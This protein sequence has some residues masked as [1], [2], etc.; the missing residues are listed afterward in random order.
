MFSCYYVISGGAIMKNVP[1]RYCETRVLGCHDR[2]EKYLEYKREREQ[3]IKARSEELDASGHVVDVLRK[4]KKR[5]R[6]K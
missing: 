4:Q 6:R 5:R 1:C 2:C 3:I